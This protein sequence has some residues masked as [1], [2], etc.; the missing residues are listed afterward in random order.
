MKNVVEVRRSRLA[1][2]IGVL[3]FLVGCT[4]LPK[5]SLDSANEIHS[6]TLNQDEK[7]CERITMEVTGLKRSWQRLFA[8]QKD[9]DRYRKILS[10]C[11]LDKRHSIDWQIFNINGENLNDKVQ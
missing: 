5:T 7:E 2:S 9:I 10:L 3:L 11:M 6:S 1:I 8:G 4:S